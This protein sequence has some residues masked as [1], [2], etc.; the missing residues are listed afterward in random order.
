MFR[1]A[2]TQQCTDRENF[3]EKY[4]QRRRSTVEAGFDMSE[5]FGQ[6]FAEYKSSK[7]FQSNPV[8]TVD[9]DCTLNSSLRRFQISPVGSDKERTQSWKTFNEI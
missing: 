2:E 4:L 8:L 9:L 5:I 6:K 1:V 3:K 7:R